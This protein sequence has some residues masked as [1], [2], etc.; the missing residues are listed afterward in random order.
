MGT[1]LLMKKPMVSVLGG[2]IYVAFLILPW[3]QWVTGV[4]S[5]GDGD[6]RVRVNV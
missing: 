3:C 1:M 6:D 5:L 2:Q 4:M